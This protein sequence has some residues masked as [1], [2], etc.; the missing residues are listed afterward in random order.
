MCNYSGAMKSEQ[1]TFRCEPW[2]KKMLTKIAA[3]EPDN[4]G[5]GEMIHRLAMRAERHEEARDADIEM[6]N[7]ARLRIPKAP[8][9]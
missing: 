9:R 2:L 8:R 1:M 7:R 5:R 6:L 3:R 4:P